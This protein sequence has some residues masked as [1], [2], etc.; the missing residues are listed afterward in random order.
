M[1]PISDLLR[2]ILDSRE[3]NN[4]DQTF[5][6]LREANAKL[7]TVDRISAEYAEELIGREMWDETRQVLE[8][9]A[10][11]QPP[12]MR[13]H[14]SFARVL[15]HFRETDQAI[16]LLKQTKL[17]NPVNVDCLVE[18]G[19][20]LLSKGELGEAKINFGEAL[21]VDG[22]SKGARQ[23][24][25]KVELIE[26]NI[27]SAMDM[28]REVSSPRELAAIFNLSAIFN[29][30]QS[31]FNKAI[32]LYKYSINLLAEEKALQ[33]K[34]YFNAGLGF[35]RWNKL[36]RALVCFQTAVELSPD[37][38][39]AARNYQLVHGIVNPQT[40][41]DLEEDE[42]NFGNSSAFS[43]GG[44]TDIDAG[45]LDQG[46]LFNMMSGMGSDSDDSTSPDAFGLDGELDLFES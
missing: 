5:A 21:E 45:S 40:K 3:Q 44:S 42:E 35:R 24:A 23:G 46:S 13:A 20:I 4:P 30:K 11:R 41:L 32:A 25:G 19:N 28:L 39:K 6:I 17:L 33:A 26:G 12:Y 9:L 18:L 27:E 10:N 34:L 15:F 31:Y 43:V 14:Q 7:P 2:R 29:I 36:E 38:E 22:E 8:P 37:Y 16:N 1:A